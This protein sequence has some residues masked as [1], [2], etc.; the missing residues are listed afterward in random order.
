MNTSSSPRFTVFILYCMY[1]FKVY[2]FII[3]LHFIYLQIY[4][5]KHLRVSA[6]IKND[7]L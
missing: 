4:L 6:F 7:I 1:I 3:P 2:V 5:L